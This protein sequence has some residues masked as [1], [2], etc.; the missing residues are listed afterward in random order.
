MIPQPRFRG[1]GLFGLRPG[2]AS[3]KRD[4]LRGWDRA[5]F[6]DTDFAR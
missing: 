3:R 2:R 1:F 4:G 5:G 6:I